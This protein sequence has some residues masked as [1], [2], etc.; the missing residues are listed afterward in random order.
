MGWNPR[1]AAA[2]PGLLGVGLM[3]VWAIHDGGYDEETWYWGALAVLALLAGSLCVLGTGRLTARRGAL[4]A[5]ACLTA[6]VGWSFATILWAQSP[7]LALLGSDKALLYLLLFT[8]FAVLPWTVTGAVA[9]LLTF[10][11]GIGATAIVLLV[12]LATGSHVGVLFVGGRLAAPTGYINSTAALFT[13]GAL[14]GIVLATRRQLWGPVRG[15]LLAFAAAELDL[16]IT[17]QSRG[18]LFTLPIVAMVAIGIMPSRLRV[19]A[20][21]GLPVIA[22][23]LDARRLLR[24]LEDTNSTSLTRLAEH[25]GRP[26]LLLCCI[27]FL[28]AT[29]VAWVDSTYPRGIGV[30]PRRVIGVVLAI[31]AIGGGLA[32]LDTV[33]SGHPGAFITRQWNGFA[34]PESSY[35]GSHFANVG[36]GRYDFWR[37]AL[38]AFRTHPIDGI[39][40]NNFG[41]YYLLHGHTGE[42]PNAP[43]SLEMTLLSETGAVGAAL[44]LAFLL[45][46]ARESLGARRRPDE[47]VR[48]TAAAALLPLLP[49]IIHGSID[50]FWEMP[51]LTAPALAFLGLAVALRTT[52]AA[53][54]ALPGIER[55][56]ARPRRLGR[57][58]IV[59]G[60]GAVFACAFIVLAFPYLSVREVSVGTDI[61]NADPAAALSDLH[62]ASWLNPLDPTPGL[63][64]GAVALRNGRTALA[65]NSFEQSVHREPDAWLSWLGAGLGE[66]ALDHRSRARADFIRARAIDRYQPVVTL[67]LRRLDGPHPLTSEQAFNMLTPVN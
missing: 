63:V 51:A 39:G 6:F 16:A 22:A 14:L 4:A 44:F 54:E 5:V 24:V 64:A 29:L 65:V 46:A 34:H 37:V 8:L 61:Q 20:A 43:H 31:V 27:V 67:A 17:V 38:H 42:N 41:D 48:F 55:P 59:V 40:S 50:W 66:S 52:P 11:V 53:G 26:G 25:A 56:A 49:W 45:L 32:V 23:A 19:T 21:A 3:L 7:G 30:W 1:S 47:L 15:A 9:A 12:R 36:S 2:L 10:A 33:S 57:P 60:V 13:M 28:V 58:V 18:W 35:S 62:A